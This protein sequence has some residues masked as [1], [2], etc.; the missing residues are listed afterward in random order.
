[1]CA[2]YPECHDPNKNNHGSP[3][4]QSPEGSPGSG[5]QPWQPMGTER[6][7]A[8]ADH[9]EGFRGGKQ[10][11]AGDH[12]DGLLAIRLGAHGASAT[13]PLPTGGAP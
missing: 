2:S 11:G 1:M 8:P 3:T 12:G 9:P 4:C 5:S 13:A 7:S 10:R 6:G